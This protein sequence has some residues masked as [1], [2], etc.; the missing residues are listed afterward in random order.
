MTTLAI[1]L[2]CLAAFVVCAAAVAF[3]VWALYYFE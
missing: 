1:I 3:V 2:L